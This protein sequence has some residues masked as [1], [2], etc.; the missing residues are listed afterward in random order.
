MVYDRSGNSI[1]QP[2]PGRQSRQDRLNQRGKVQSRQ[3]QIEEGKLS[4]KHT[5]RYCIFQLK[6]VV[7]KLHHSNYQYQCYYL[8]YYHYTGAV[9]NHKPEAPS[10]PSCRWVWWAIWLIPV[11]PHV[12]RLAINIGRTGI[13][14]VTSIHITYS[15]LRL[16]IPLCS[17][18]SRFLSGESLQ[19]FRSVRTLITSLFFLIRICSEEGS[20]SSKESPKT[21]WLTHSCFRRRVMR[22]DSA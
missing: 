17:A 6:P 1:L 22:C 15:T 12:Q 5:E 21:N 4:T 11:A 3:L 13:S 7:P 16:E 8:Y 2:E 19:T 9:L 10:P 14:P 18:T 20:Q